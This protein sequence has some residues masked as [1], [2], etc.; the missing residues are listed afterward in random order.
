MIRHAI[1]LGV[2]QIYLFLGGS[3][4]ND[5]GLGIATALGF[6]LLDVIGSVLQPNGGNLQYIHRIEK[7]TEI[8]ANV[9]F[10]LLCDVNNP[11]IGLNGAAYVYAAQKGATP[12]Q[13][14][15]LDQGLIH[16]C[17]RIHKQFGI[18]VEEL[19]G[20]G[21]AGGGGAGLHA[22]FGAQLS[23]GFQTISE[24]T[25]FKEKLAD[26]D[27]VISGEGKLD[28]QSLAGKVVD[29]V[30]ALC[31]QYQKPL[32]IFA[33]AMDL[34]PAQLAELKIVQTCTVIDRAKS[35]E[36]AMENAAL[37]LT[38]MAAEIKW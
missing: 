18:S 32:Y 14:E 12:T 15:A 13:I 2:S 33:G 28:G 37:Y 3:A 36:D 17:Q 20:G 27:I 35:M 6:Q 31:R 10:N 5:L 7:I 21:A 30:A 23:P 16:A 25:G 22:L 9:Q 34:S 4:T 24:L 19:P 38:E 8:A 29:G 1:E 11:T 26:A